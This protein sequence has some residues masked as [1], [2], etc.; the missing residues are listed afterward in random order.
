VKR[1]AQL[2]LYFSICFGVIFPVT[3]L[4]RYLYLWIDAARFIPAESIGILASVISAGQWALP[5]A[6]YIAILVTLSYSVRKAFPVS[7]SMLCIFILACGFGTGVSLGLL[8]A[9]SSMVL[10][11]EVTPPAL[12]GPGLILT[13]GETTVILMDEPSNPAGSRVIAIPGRPLIYQ[14]KPAGPAGGA[15][16]LPP[17]PFRIGGPYFITDLFIDFS[18]AARQFRDRLEQGLVPFGIYL[19]ALCLLLSSLRFILELSSWPLCNIFLGALVF[20]GILTAETFLDSREIQKFIGSLLKNN[21]PQGFITP[22]IFCGAA[23]LV[24][25]YTVLVNLARGRKA[26]R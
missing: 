1:L 17:L 3:V 22:G 11:G 19:G 2:S 18:L 25:L 5:I 26:S 6:V 15:F 23:L 10:P 8:R 12:G 20:R 21:V 14:K 13:Q 9:N 16:T 7:L 24:I 4:L